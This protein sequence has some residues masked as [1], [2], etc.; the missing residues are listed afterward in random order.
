MFSVTVRDHM[1]VAHSLSG[2]VFGPAQRLHGATF[3]V[4]A[5]FRRPDL[6]D[7]GIVVDIG[8]AT[9]ELREVLGELTYRNLDDEPL[10]KGTNTTTEVLARRRRRPALRPDPRRRPGRGCARDHRPSRSRCTSPTSRGRA[11]SGRHE[12]PEPHVHVVVPE[13]V[14]DPTRPSGGNVYDRRL[15]QELTRS[16]WSVGE[17]PVTDTPAGVAALASCPMPAT[18]SCWSTGWSLSGRRRPCSREADRLRI[19]VLLHMPFGERDVEARVVRVRGADGGDGRGD[20]E[21]VEPAVG[22]RALRAATRAGVRRRSPV[23]T[24]PSSPT[25]SATGG[26]LLCV[27]AVTPDKGHAVLL[28][29]L[30][31]VGDLPWHLTCVGSLDRDR[32][33]VER[34]QRHAV[35][36]GIADRVTWTGALV[37]ARLDKAYAAADVLVLATRAESWGMV[38]AES[39]ARGVPV[40]ATEV[41]GLPEALGSIADGAARAAG[42]ARRRVRAGLGAASLAHRRPPCVDDLR[43][44]ARERRTT[45]TGWSVT[46]EKV[47][48][49]LEEVAR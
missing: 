16:G 11:T 26:E 14:D 32:A 18:R 23:S 2:E 4:D 8:R 44:A 34:L 17:H 45:L 36:L 10:L 28:A 7:D 37:G 30:A 42:A 25:G 29:A 12:R 22:G 43:A 41:G 49:V 13:G 3:V 15:V 39:L 48:R 40:V 19:V 38:V 21:R 47:A 9:T 1:M 20:H 33:L 5:T 31:E 27:A 35:E 46:A 6:D 24:P